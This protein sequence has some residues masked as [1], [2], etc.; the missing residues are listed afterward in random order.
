MDVSEA[1]ES[2]TGSSLDSSGSEVRTYHLS[3]VEGAGLR[4]SAV[5]LASSLFLNSWT[6]LP[7]VLACLNWTPP[8]PVCETELGLSRALQRQLGPVGC[9]I[10]ARWRP[11]C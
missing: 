5:W 3:Q 10:L 2:S 6:C 1:W 11:E 4:A 7:L 8:E 9:H